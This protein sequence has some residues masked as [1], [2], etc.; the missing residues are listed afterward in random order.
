MQKALQ[1]NRSNKVPQLSVPVASQY[2]LLSQV[3]ES[4]MYFQRAI[5]VTFEMAHELMKVFHMLLGL[6]SI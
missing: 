2:V 3:E 6:S 1:L 4:E 5:S